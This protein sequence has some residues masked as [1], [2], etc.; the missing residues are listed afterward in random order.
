MSKVILEFDGI[1]EQE[2]IQTALNGW[3]WKSFVWDLD[4]KLRS[5]VKYGTSIIDDSKLASPDEVEIADKYREIIREML[6]D[7][8]LKLD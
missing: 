6:H 5:T 8:G 2:E 7:S 4:Q 3:K 1:E